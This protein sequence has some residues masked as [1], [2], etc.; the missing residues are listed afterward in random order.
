MSER[1]DRKDLP[2]ELLA[3]LTKGKSRFTHTYTEQVFD[4][5]NRVGENCSIDDVLIAVYREHGVIMKRTFVTSALYRL[6]SK[7]RIGRVSHGLYRA[8]GRE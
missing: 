1:F 5:V 4:I 3:Q 8:V 7:K 2:P 6:A